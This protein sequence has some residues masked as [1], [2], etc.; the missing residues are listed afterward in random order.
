MPIIEDCAGSFFSKDKKD[1]IGKI[2]DFVI[3]SFPKMFPLQIG[4]LL[5]SNQKGSIEKQDQ[6]DN[7]T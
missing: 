3:Y 1:T 2:G 7:L 5:L 6:M 4:G